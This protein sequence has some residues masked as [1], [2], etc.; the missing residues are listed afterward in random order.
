ML[1]SRVAP[2]PRVAVRRNKEGMIVL[3]APLPPSRLA[4][5][6]PR[7][8]QGPAP[9]R[10]ITLDEI[11]S[12]VWEMCGPDATVA[13]MARRLVEKYQMNPREAEVALTAFIRTLARKN[14]AVIAVPRPDEGKNENAT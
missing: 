2:N 4:T 13:E 7:L 1:Q 5:W 12:F 9:V 11:G 10:E 6:F 8:F 3:G 14:L